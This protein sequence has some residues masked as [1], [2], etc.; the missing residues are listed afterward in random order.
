MANVQPYIPSHSGEGSNLSGGGFAGNSGEILGNQILG[1]GNQLSA[2]V[3]NSNR[4]V[5]GNIA[6]VAGEATN[7]LINAMATAQAAKKTQQALT[8]NN[9]AQAAIGDS[10]RRS[11]DL[12]H[13]M[14]KDPSKVDYTPEGKDNILDIMDN[15]H[16]V[17]RATLAKQVA[18]LNGGN[19][20]LALFDANREKSKTSYDNA[21]NELDSTSAKLRA[22]NNYQDSVTD[23]QGRLDGSVGSLRQQQAN[24]YSDSIASLAATAG[25]N[26]K[27]DTA[28][29]WSLSAINANMAKGNIQNWS[30]YLDNAKGDVAKAATT[31]LNDALALQKQLTTDPS[32]GAGLMNPEVKTRLMGDVDT[33][34]NNATAKVAQV[35]AN[36]AQLFSLQITHNELGLRDKSPSIRGQSEA[37]IQHIQSTIEKTISTLPP[38]QQA[39]WIAAAK[40]ADEARIKASDVG[41]A[42]QANVIAVEGQNAEATYRNE[43]ATISNQANSDVALKKQIYISDELAS[44]NNAIQQAEAKHPHALKNGYVDT[45][46]H[47]DSPRV[48]ALQNAIETQRKLTGDNDTYSANLKALNAISLKAFSTNQNNP[49]PETDAITDWIKATRPLDPRYLNQLDHRIKPGSPEAINAL[50]Q[51]NLLADKY[52]KAN[53]ALQASQARSQA[54][55]QLLK[56]AHMAPPQTYNPPQKPQMPLRK[57]V[58]EMSE[59]IVTPEQAENYKKKAGEPAAVYVRGANGMEKRMQ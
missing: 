51:V 33:L 15:P 48:K 25:I 5:I 44:M 18:G 3:A 56:Y 6:S 8:A 32:Y 55:I 21:F 37:N 23:M 2:D 28:N 16:E 11:Q 30:A 43:T 9:M 49:A 7:S 58:D 22:N 31:Q 40:Q 54:E 53:P 10:D 42:R 36:S 13:Q 12:W 39:P 45:S 52:R 17:N 19:Q 46:G 1:A 50:K 59:E 35:N 27:H 38:D 57:T 41:V 4:Q 24:M 26:S 14:T 34:V 29:L 20:A 47:V